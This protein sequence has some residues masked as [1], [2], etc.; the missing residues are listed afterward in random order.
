MIYVL[1]QN[2]ELEIIKA[3]TINKH[4]EA[5]EVQIALST[6]GVPADVRVPFRQQHWAH[7]QATSSQICHHLRERNKT[8]RI[9]VVHVF[10][11]ASFLIVAKIFYHLQVL[12]LQ[13]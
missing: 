2:E 10:I 3:L 1:T 11:C 8:M 9:L 13:R 7:L 6:A 12:L 4:S 5:E